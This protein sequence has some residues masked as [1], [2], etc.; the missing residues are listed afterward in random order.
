MSVAKF[1]MFDELEFVG[2]VDFSFDWNSKDI[3]INGFNY[4]Y[5]IM[6]KIGN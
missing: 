1:D 5:D 2:I 6:K 4:D 3:C